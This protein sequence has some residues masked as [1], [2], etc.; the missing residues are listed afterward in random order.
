M[1]FRTRR[2]RTK[3]DGYERTGYE[4]KVDYLA[5]PDIR[6]EEIYL[7]TVDE[8]GPTTTT[9]RYE[10]AANNDRANANRHAGYRLETIL[11]EL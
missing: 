11:D 4:R 2:A 5:D 10:P 8:T 7:I 6:T 9:I 1:E 3:S